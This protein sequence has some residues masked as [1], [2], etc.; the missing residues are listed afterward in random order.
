MLVG[1]INHVMLFT[2]ARFFTGPVV[3]S[4]WNEWDLDQRI[5]RSSSDSL[6]IEALEPTSNCL[7]RSW[8][9]KPKLETP[10]L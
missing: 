4:L 5:F 9:S 1:A 2:T 3:A 8:I 7:G 10:G 6:M